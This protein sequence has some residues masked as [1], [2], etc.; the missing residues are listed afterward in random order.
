MV[1][2]KERYL[3]QFDIWHEFKGSKWEGLAD[4]FSKFKNIYNYEFVWLPDDDL[5][6]NGETLNNFFSVVKKFNFTISQPALTTYSYFT[7]AITLQNSQYIARNTNFIEIMAPCFQVSQLPFFVKT[8]GENSSGFGYEYI[9]G[10]IAAKKKM[11]N[12]GIVDATPVYHTRPVGSLGH[13]G[14]K[15]NPHQEEKLILEKYSA[16]RYKP[17][18][19]KNHPLTSLRF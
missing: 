17:R 19:I 3:G 16:R 10:L 7:W 14:A 1:N 18:V 13:G 15:S 9:W 8:F 12:F 11:L 6:V 2:K 5:F 4:F